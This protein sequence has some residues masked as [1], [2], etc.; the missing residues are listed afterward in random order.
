MS[1]ETLFLDHDLISQRY[2]FPR[3]DSFPH[4]F[5]IPCEGGISLVCRYFQI[6]GVA[7]EDAKTMVHFHGNGEVVSD[8]FG[9]FKDTILRMGVHLLLVEYRG[10]GS[11]TGIPSL[12][13]I[14]EDT[15]HIF[16]A[17]GKKAEDLIVF[18]RSIGSI[19]AIDFA[20]CYPDVAGLILESGIAD[21]LERVLLRV[22]P[23]ELGTDLERLE[24]ESSRFLDHQRKLESF[25]NPLLVL[26]TEHDG[27]VDRSHA[28]RNFKWCASEKKQLL[29]FENGT[30]NSILY[31]N[32]DEYMDTIGS[33]I[34][35]L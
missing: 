33:F 20:H 9:P 21:P 32:W 24:S 11:S 6:P 2:F 10:Y 23:A 5:A 12:V 18:G 22:S 17:I 14:L 27:L 3:D 25:H 28:D 19:Y 30:H 13:G 7:L 15:S 26:H 35:S 29:V 34:R 4:A 1:S 31:T 16:R 8:Y